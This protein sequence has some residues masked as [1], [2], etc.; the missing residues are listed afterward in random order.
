M[1]TV[2]G[3]IPSMSGNGRTEAGEIHD[4]M[5]HPVVEALD[6]ASARIPRS[7]S[8][9]V[10]DFMFENAV[11]FWGEVNPEFFK[12]TVVEKPAAEVLARGR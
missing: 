2:G 11:R 10:A 6:V 12:G 4:R 5:K 9:S 8:M 3:I 1:R 7:L